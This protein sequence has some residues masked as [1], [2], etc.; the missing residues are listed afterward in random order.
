MLENQ[1]EILQEAMTQL[2]RRLVQLEEDA[3]GSIFD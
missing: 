1:V 2:N 3:T